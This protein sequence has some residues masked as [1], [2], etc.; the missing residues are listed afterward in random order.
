MCNKKMQNNSSKLFSVENKVVIITGSGKGIGYH[1]AT[2][3]AK[4]DAIVYCLDLKFPNKIPKELS[5]VLFQKKCDI[6]NNKD[7]E[8]KCNEIYS[9]HKR[10]DVLI[11]NAGVTFPN[12]TSK[13]YSYN[14]WYKTIELNLSAC[15]KCSQIAIKHMIKNKRG[16]IINITSIN[17]K[18]AFPNNPAYVASKGGLRMLSK[19]LA[20]DWGKFGIRVNN[21]AP[22]YIL[23][24]MTKK[25]FE[26]KT[27]RK[28]RESRTML[29]RWGIPE[30]LVG[31]CIFLCSDASNYITGL[32]LYVDG[33][34]TYNGLSQ[35]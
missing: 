5:K 18:L 21:L 24:E 29:G 16:V 22:G 14:N 32:D 4:R 30:D 9:I 35:E 27:T 1:L 23:T 34:W 10:I 33:G 6:L 15:F 8:K 25:S 26:N 2:N 13:Y 31:P 28:N 11:N 7:F 3:L 20:R 12:N 17:S 19:S